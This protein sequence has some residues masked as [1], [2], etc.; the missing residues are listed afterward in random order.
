M[1]RRK[2]KSPVTFE[3]PPPQRERPYDWDAIAAALREK[4]RQWAKV[5]DEDRASL[6]TAIR[7]HGI[8][9]LD[10]DKGFEVRTANNYKPQPGSDE[11]RTCSMYLRYVPEKDQERGKD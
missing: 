10:P 1:T 7:I 9:A 8:K 6:A 11:V 2:V 5:F 4:P 3:D